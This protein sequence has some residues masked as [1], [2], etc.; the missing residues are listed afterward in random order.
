MKASGKSIRRFSIILALIMQAPAH[1][2]EPTPSREW[3]STAGTTIEASATAM[4]DGFVQLTTADGRQIPVRLANL[5]DEDRSFL[6]KHFRPKPPQGLPYPIGK[7][8]GPHQTGTGSS[9]FVYI[10]NSLQDGRKAPLLL[11]TGAGGGNRRIV[12][13]HAAGAELNGWIVAASVESRNGQSFEINHEHAKKCVDHLITTLPVDPDRLY[14]SGNSGGGAMAFINTAKLKGAGAMPLIGYNMDKEYSRSGHYYVL[15][16]TND[17]NR[18]PSAQAAS[19]AKA[20][21]VHRLYPGG[22]N[23]APGWITTEGMV[24]LNGRYLESKSNEA[25]LAAERMDWEENMI[26]WIGELR[27]SEAHRAYYWCY[28][29]QKTY[30]ISGPNAARINA[31]GDDL[32]RDPINP[33]YAEGIDAIK[34]F[35]RK[36]LAD[37]GSGS[38]FSHTTPK[39]QSAAAALEQQYAGVPHVEEVFKR[40]GQKTVAR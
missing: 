31:I 10:P 19:G 18:Y 35:S 15:G 5:I 4:K 16:G 28:F 22:H 11:F 39:I 30:K 25:T 20:R 14:F 26:A 17:Y 24:W 2:A 3:K 37:I 1:S 8:S 29:L 7:A 21:G 36:H 13:A 23:G 34:E 12:E 32:A 40:L 9:Y 33:R 6:L 38:L 27:K